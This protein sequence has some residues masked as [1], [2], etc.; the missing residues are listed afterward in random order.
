MGHLL[1]WVGEQRERLGTSKQRSRCWRGR[2]WFGPAGTKP[3][4]S[5]YALSP[6]GRPKLSLRTGGAD[7]P[8]GTGSPPVPTTLSGGDTP[9][10]PPTR[11]LIHPRDEIVQVMERIYRYRM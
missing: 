10:N 9:M 8:Q 4:E 5:R 2:E 1:E 6:A 11:P 3:A 7:G